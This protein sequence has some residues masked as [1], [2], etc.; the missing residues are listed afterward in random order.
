MRSPGLGPHR[1]RV[2]AIALRGR[3]LY[4]ARVGRIALITGTPGG[5]EAALAEELERAGWAVRHAVFMGGEIPDLRA[6]AA[7]ADAV[8]HVGVRTSREETPERRAGQ[9]AAATAASALAAR[10]AGARRFV[11]LSTAS[12]YGHPRSLPCAEGDPKNP[13]T[14]AERARWGAER[15]AWRAFRDGAPLTVLR[16]AILYGPGMR[17][18]AIRAL[19]L[20]ALFSLGR[21]RI[22]IIRRGPVT[23]L[24]HIQDL[25]RAAVHVAEHPDD[26]DVL[27]RAFNVGDDAPLPLAEHLSAALAAM[28]YSPGRVLPYSPRVAALLLWLVRSIPDRFLFMPVNR[29]LAGA[30]GRIASRSHASPALAPRLDRESLHWMAADHYYDTRRLSDLGWRPEHPIS[31][32]ALPGTIQS[33]LSAGL[34]PEAATHSL[35]AA[36]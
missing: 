28:G 4:G 1:A 30:W 23:H 14:F 13:R 8:F 17:G 2:R 16:P 25:A 20:I 3:L 6:E 24:C 31:T 26:R 36:L 33:L 19:S 18:G 10:D 12:V 32:A 7:N 15:A 35:P 22:P 29:R 21:R 27:G 9:E 5:R 34:L 11:L